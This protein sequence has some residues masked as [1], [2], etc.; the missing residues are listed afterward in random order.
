MRLRPSLSDSQL[1]GSLDHA[2]AKI[3]NGTELRAFDVP[4]RTE[5]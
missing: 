5:V 2:L 4:L 1:V 3:S